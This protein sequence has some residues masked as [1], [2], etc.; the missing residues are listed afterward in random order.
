M[1]YLVLTFFLFACFSTMPQNVFEIKGVVRDSTSNEPIEFANI[2]LL[3]NNSIGV[4]SNQEGY[5]NLKIDVADTIAFSHVGYNTATIC[6]KESKSFTEIKLSK[7]PIELSE[8]VVKPIDA[9]SIM[10]K[11]SSNLRSNHFLK[12]TYYKLFVRVFETTDDNL[13]V[14]EE[15]ILHLYQKIPLPKFKII[16]GRVK[17]FSEKEIKEFKEKKFYNVV[18]IYSDYHILFLSDFLK[19]NRFKRYNYTFLE[20]VEIDGYTCYHLLC[21][22]KK[23]DEVIHLYVEQNS[24]GLVRIEVLSKEEKYTAESTTLVNFIKIGKQWHLKSSRY[25][26]IPDWQLNKKVERICMYTVIDNESKKDYKNLLK[27]AKTRLDIFKSEFDD[28]F[29]G[30]NNFVPIPKY[31][32][33][34]M[35]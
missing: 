26:Y 9:T 34:Q 21:K 31:I 22:S 6:S 29:W 27:I 23:G 13:D 17:P 16:K 19:Q 15:Y 30:N 10:N 33:K 18:G 35:E 32:K 5:F 4:I 24:Y 2:Y 12:S 7:K 11:V 14:I 3:S 20:P 1:R 8:V 25:M 28:D